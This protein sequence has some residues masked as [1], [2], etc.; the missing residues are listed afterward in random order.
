MHSNV[1]FFHFRSD[2]WILIYADTILIP[3]L[4]ALI[5]S[6]KNPYKKSFQSLLDLLN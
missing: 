1:Y 2:T 3:E 6:L 4:F 5:I